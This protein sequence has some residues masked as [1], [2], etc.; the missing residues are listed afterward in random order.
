LPVIAD[1]NDQCRHYH[2]GVVY[3][4]RRPSQLNQDITELSDY[5]MIYHLTGHRDNLYLND[6]V[7]GLGDSAKA[8]PPYHYILVRPD[9]SYHVMAPIALK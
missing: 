4:A 6:I 2:L 9:R 8:L 7:A 3:I 5:M 1:L